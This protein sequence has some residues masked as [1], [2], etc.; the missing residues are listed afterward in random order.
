MNESPAVA[1]SGRK[2]SGGTGVLRGIGDA[3][4]AGHSPQVRP[5]RA[6][7]SFSVAAPAGRTTRDLA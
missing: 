2:S 4:V 1:C 3:P 5:V 6:V 7:H